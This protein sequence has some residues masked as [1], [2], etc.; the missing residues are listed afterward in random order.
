MTT[1]ELNPGWDSNWDSADARGHDEGPW[2]RWTTWA[3]QCAA[4]PGG[5]RPLPPRP[6]VDSSHDELIA[7]WGPLL[8][9]TSY[10][11]GWADAGAG[12]L[13]WVESGTPV[14]DP[15]LALIQRWWGPA[16]PDLLAYALGGHDI[17][18][19]GGHISQLVGAMAPRP[20]EQ[21]PGND[22]LTRL[23]QQRREDPRWQQVWAGGGDPL[24]L[25]PHCLAPVQAGP[26]PDPVVRLAV[27]LPG[28][29]VLTT[30]RYDGWYRA[31]AEHGAGL[32]PSQDGRSWRISVFCLPIGYLGTYRQSRDS[33]RWFAGRHRWHQLGA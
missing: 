8:H 30:N 7:F 15:R 24:H 25:T 16:L 31:L 26:Q 3:W 1:F 10:G 27:E 32:P 5:A 6:D 9:L 18:A 29:A 11:L 17:Q 14:T 21:V 2:S 4:D 13:R 23:L 19:V 33:G 22:D 28:R 20:Q 12:L